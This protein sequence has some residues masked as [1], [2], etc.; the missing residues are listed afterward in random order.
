MK[1][2]AV[3]AVDY[4]TEVVA[5]EDVQDGDA[6]Q[7]AEAPLSA[8]EQKERMMRSSFTSSKSTS[9]RR[10]SRPRRRTTR[11]RT[12]PSSAVR[13]TSTPFSW[14]SSSPS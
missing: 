2:T 3:V 12:T 10:T 4:E 8:E 7:E 14:M 9:A 6:R 5:S 13:T 1:P 11:L